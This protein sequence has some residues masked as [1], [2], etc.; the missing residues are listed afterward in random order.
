M[1]ELVNKLKLLGI[2][3]DELLY[4]IN[5]KEYI[6]TDQLKKEV[7]VALKQVCT[8]LPCRHRCARVNLRELLST[9]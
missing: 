9:L 8:R 2:L 1:I 4:T 3:G 5:G 7:E 6:T